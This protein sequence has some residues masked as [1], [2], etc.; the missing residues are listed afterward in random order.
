M[1]GVPS[2]R[3]VAAPHPCP[4]AQQTAQRGWHPALVCQPCQHL[5]QAPGFVHFRPASCGA[6]GDALSLAHALPHPT[7]PRAPALPS[8]AHL[9]T[10][11][12]P[13]GPPSPSFSLLPCMQGCP[14][15]P[16]CV[17]RP[18][19]IPVSPTSHPH[20]LL[21]LCSITPA[22]LQCLPT[23]TNP[24]AHACACMHGPSSPSL[25][26]SLFKALTSRHSHLM[27]A[28]FRSTV[29]RLLTP[30]THRI[31]QW[32]ERRCNTRGEE[33]QQS[34]KAPSRRAGL[35]GYLAGYLAAAPLAAHSSASSLP[36]WL[37]SARS[38]HPSLLARR[39]P[40]LLPV[41]SARAATPLCYLL[42]P[43][44]HV[45]RS[46]QQWAGRAASAETMHAGPCTGLDLQPGRAI[47]GAAQQAA[48]GWQCTAGAHRK[49]A[50]GP[51]PAT[52]RCGPS[53]AARRP[54]ALP[55]G[56]SAGAR[57]RLAHLHCQMQ[58]VALGEGKA[59]P[60]HT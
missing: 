47:R 30:E 43:N 38:S 56:A 44:G 37:W 50:P 25:L 2:A 54:L 32:C 9:P 34:R 55:V 12:M 15:L 18:L 4:P 58:G 17:P 22:S 6:A 10:M 36:A 21:C 13:L 7:P 28:A 1:S 33:H 52:H 31:P 60:Q 53:A 35:A 29:T 11:T 8:F 45:P 42:L 16:Y 40:A 3:A 57:R 19:M 48:G 59:A 51:G 49:T 23:K 39:V 24:P 41:L 20:L 27:Y 26:H 46:L 14:R 5:A